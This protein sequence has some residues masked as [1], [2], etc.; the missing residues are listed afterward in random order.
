MSRKTISTQAPRQRAFLVGVDLK[1]EGNLLPI[2]ESLVEL[3]LLAQTAG[4]EIV[5]TAT[6]SLNRP[7]PR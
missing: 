2:E 3:E 5:G 1:S 6:Q 7:D 4:L